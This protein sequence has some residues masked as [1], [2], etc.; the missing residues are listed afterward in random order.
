MDIQWNKQQD[1]RRKLSQVL[2]GWFRKLGDFMPVTAI[3]ALDVT[4]VGVEDMRLGLPSDFPLKDHARLGIT[5]HGLI[6]REL[7]I[8]QA[9]DALKKLRIQLGLKSFLVRWK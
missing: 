5:D 3:Q 2:D 9:H 6:E 8:G 4:N 7:R 1:A